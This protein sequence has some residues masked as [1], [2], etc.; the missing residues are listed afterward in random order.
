M[1][2]VPDDE[3]DIPAYIWE[4]GD[5][6]GDEDSGPDDSPF[7]AMGDDWSYVHDSLSV[8]HDIREAEYTRISGDDME[9]YL[10]DMGF[11][12]LPRVPRRERIYQKLYGRE[13]MVP[14]CSRVST[15]R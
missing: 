10:T 3:E 8:H 4:W 7:S 13:R 11:E 5:L 15:H 14:S 2:L 1:A 6:P 9:D 12:E